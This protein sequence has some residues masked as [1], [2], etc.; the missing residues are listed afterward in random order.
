MSELSVSGLSVRLGRTQVLDKID[1]SL[2]R[3]EVTVIVGPNGAGKSTLLRLLLGSLRPSSGRI[4][5]GKRGLHELPERVRARRIAYVA[6]RPSIAFAFTV[7]EFVALGRYAVAGSDD[8]R[9][10]D[11]ALARVDLADRAR[12]IFQALSVGQQQRAA[13]ARALA[14]LDVS[15]PGARCPA[16]DTALPEPQRPCPACGLGS[17]LLAD[18]PVSAMDPRHALETMGVLRDLA[19]AGAT[20]AVVL[21][22]LS[23]AARYCDRAL[24]LTA[25]GRCAACGPLAESFA[26]GLL[27]SV[28]GVRFDRATLSDGGLA[29]V[30]TLA[31]G[32]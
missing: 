30:P 6:Q 4:L 17:V 12:D 21:H 10:T 14:Q 26:P 8:D 19:D 18:E 22:D 13:L 23:A 28:F 24:V 7:R 5:L 32:H 20:V 15:H 3:G 2:R 1:L 9:A 25:D 16:C 29:L 11:A 27:E 31:A